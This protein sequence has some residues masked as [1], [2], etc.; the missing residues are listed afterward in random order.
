[1]S[2]RGRR[3]VSFGVPQQHDELHEV[4]KHCR[5]WRT[6]VHKAGVNVNA[7]IRHDIGRIW[8]ELISL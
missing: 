7:I 1:M 5:R 6:S 3:G 2:R 4:G 8:Q